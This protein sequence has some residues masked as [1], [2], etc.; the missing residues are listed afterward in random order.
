MQKE[1]LPEM[2]DAYQKKLV[3]LNMISK[4]KNVINQVMG[5][6]TRDIGLSSD[7]FSDLNS[8]PNDKLASVRSGSSQMINGLLD[9]R[10]S[11]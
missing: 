3:Y 1:K 4:P 10:S 9:V 6:T 5:K 8:S 2:S 11:T 7:L